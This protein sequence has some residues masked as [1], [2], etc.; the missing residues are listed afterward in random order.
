V[1]LVTVKDKFQVT[2]PARLRRALALEV[3]DVMEAAL[4][5]DRIVLRPKAV[6]DRAA[7]ADRLEVTLGDPP[8]RRKTIRPWP[9]RSPC[10]PRCRLEATLGD[11]PPA[12]GSDHSAMAEAIAEVAAARAAR[13]RGKG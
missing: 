10:R 7:L 5:D 2:I 1:P 9:K 11:P 8:P 6:I 13:R 3:G 12:D 4:E